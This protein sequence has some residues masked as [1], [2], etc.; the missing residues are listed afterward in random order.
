[1]HLTELLKLS[2]IAIVIIGLALRLRTTLVVVV[3][4]LV[5][6][7]AAGLPLFSSDGCSFG[8]RLEFWIPEW[9]TER[10]VAAVL[11]AHLALADCRPGK[12]AAPLR[13]A[14]ST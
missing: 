9:M 7:I 1:M 11:P 2:G 8:L 13:M 6:G 14:C 5:T 10:A 4:G 12:E 3:A